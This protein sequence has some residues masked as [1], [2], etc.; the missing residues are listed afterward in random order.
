MRSK[1]PAHVQTLAPGSSIF[2]AERLQRES[3]TS[4]TMLSARLLQRESS[5]SIV[6]ALSSPTPRGSSISI[7][8]ILHRVCS[9]S[10]SLAFA[11][12]QLFRELRLCLRALRKASCSIQHTPRRLPRSSSC[13]Q[14]RRCQIV[15][16]AP[17]GKDKTNMSKIDHRKMSCR[18]YSARRCS[19]Q[20]RRQRCLFTRLHPLKA[21]PLLRCRR[22]SPSSAQPAARNLRSMFKKEQPAQTFSSTFRR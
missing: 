9:I 11:S 21:A 7:A 3:S 16:S 5:I 1:S 12:D 15:S 19:H 13:H 14:T 8:T 4:S 6:T 20:M 22:L 17:I 10:T 18:L 2:I